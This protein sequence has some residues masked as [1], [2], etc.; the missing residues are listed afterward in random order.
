VVEIFLA[1]TGQAGLHGTAAI[2]STHVK[3]HRPAAGRVWCRL[4][5]RCRVATQYDKLGRNYLS[6]A[7]VAAALTS[8]VN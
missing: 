8:W 2:D 4:K 7:F 6:G 5:D 3:A 1:L